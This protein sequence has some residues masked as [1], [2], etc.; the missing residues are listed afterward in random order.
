MQLLAA[1]TIVW[2]YYSNTGVL[3][4]PF[5]NDIQN[6]INNHSGNTIDTT[7]IPDSLRIRN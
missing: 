4:F 7:E 5:V 2:V 3:G 6:Y 1:I